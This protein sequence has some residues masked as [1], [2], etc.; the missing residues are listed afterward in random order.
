MDRC[1]NEG[2]G[3]NKVSIYFHLKIFKETLHLFCANI[4][5]GQM[6][7]EAQNLLAKM[8]FLLVCG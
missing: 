4:F 7:S 5:T 6:A 8:G 2:K 1:K 3:F